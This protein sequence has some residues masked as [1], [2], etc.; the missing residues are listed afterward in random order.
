MFKE[1]STGDL[2][3]DTRN[4]VNF[5]ASSC[6]SETLIFD[7]LLLSKAYK[8]LDKRL[9]KSYVSRHWRVIQKK[10]N[11]WEKLILEKYAFFVRCRSLEAVSGR[12]F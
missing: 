12:Y 3:I 4:W 6:K 1:K 2:K 11:S 5:H 10:A 9:Q 8:V 7:G